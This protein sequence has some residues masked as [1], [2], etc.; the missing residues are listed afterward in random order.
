MKKTA[1]IFSLFA[2]AALA[3]TAGCGQKLPDGMP[4]LYPTSI[5][6]TIDGKPMEEINVNLYPKTAGTLAGLA[7]FGRTDANGVA[8]IQ[9]NGL[10]DGCPEGEFAV[11]ASKTRTVHGPTMSNYDGSPLEEAAARAFAEKVE[12]EREEFLVVGADY[13][14]KETTP[15]TMSVAKGKNAQTFDIPEDGTQ[16]KF[17]K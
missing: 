14:A 11:C 3:L 5:T 13:N 9:T 15:L 4:K 17:A 2:V 10:Y 6:I 16:T 7:I 12:N 1:I 8:K